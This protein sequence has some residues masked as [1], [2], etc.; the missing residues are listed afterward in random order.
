M[1]V[2]LSLKG[3]TGQLHLAI[4]KAPSD[5]I[6]VTPKIIPLIPSRLGEMTQLKNALE[7]VYKKIDS[8]D[9]EGLVPT[10]KKTAQE[11]N[12]LLTYNDIRRGPENLEICRLESLWPRRNGGIITRRPNYLF[13]HISVDSPQTLVSEIL[14]R[15]LSRSHLFPRFLCA[16]D[17]TSSPLELSDHVFRYV[18]EHSGTISGPR[19]SLKLALSIPRLRAR[20]LF[21]KNT[22]CAA[23]HLFRTPRLPFAS[24][25]S[26]LMREFSKKFQRYLCSVLASPK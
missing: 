11:A 13:K 20:E 10:W 25:I 4:N 12:S 1:A 23:N 5:L 9:L 26:D 8:V 21:A 24:A 16:N 22:I 7:K 18:A 2:E 19:Y 17:T 15:D 6:A 3:I 14:L